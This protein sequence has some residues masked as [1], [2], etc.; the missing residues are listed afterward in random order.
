MFPSKWAN[1]RGRVYQ[2]FNLILVP[3]NRTLHT[4]AFMCLLNKQ[5]H[6]EGRREEGKERR[7]VDK[8]GKRQG[9]VKSQG[10]HRMASVRPTP[11]SLFTPRPRE[12][13][14]SLEDTGHR[15]LQ[16]NP[17]RYW[18]PQPTLNPKSTL[19]PLGAP[20]RGYCP[21]LRSSHLSGSSLPPAAAPQGPVVA[22]MN[23]RTPRNRAATVSGAA[24]LEGQAAA[25]LSTGASPTTSGSALARE[26]GGVGP[27]EGGS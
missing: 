15:S 6:R 8:K 1:F 11:T 25:M 13:P 17:S 22:D 10:T 26:P 5:T 16:S 23:H 14:R 4:S 7:K 2:S 12:V 18:G 20:H 27:W 9:T 19:P 3:R 21:T 24:G